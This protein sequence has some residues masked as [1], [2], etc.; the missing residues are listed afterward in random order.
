MSMRR[1]ISLTAF[2]SFFVTLLT[3]IILYIVP[4]GRVAYWADWRLWTLSKEQWGAIHINVGFLFLVSLL[5]HIYYNWKP[6]VLYLKNK[7]K[8]LKIF[9][10]E[11][12]AALI[13]TLLFII[14]TYAEI[15]PFSTII[16]ISDGFKDSAAKE[17]GEPPYGH[18]ELSSIKT[19]AKK[20]NIDLKKALIL[21]EKSGYKVDNETQ[22]LKEIAIQNG[23]S[24][25]KIYHAMSEAYEKTSKG[26]NKF[27]SLPENP[28]P[29]TGNLTLADFCTQ[30]N[31]SIKIITRSLIESN[32]LAKADMTIKE[33]GES[34]KISP[35]DLYEKIKSISDMNNE[36]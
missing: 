12:N 7:S 14:G 20:V 18:A 15:P 16:S 28:A 22:T 9:T 35:M 21:L 11:F 32:I 31:L 6:I 8:Q 25:Q 4:Q 34:N 3:S 26:F 19:F 36:N 2:I 10:K 23:V 33:I 30:H 5:F 24:P 13:L 27:N 17:Y 1:I 29:G